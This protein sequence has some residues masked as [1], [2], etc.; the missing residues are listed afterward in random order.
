MVSC[1]SMPD[2]MISK[3]IDFTIFSPAAKFMAY[4]VFCVGGFSFSDSFFLIFSTFELSNTNKQI[5]NT[6]ITPRQMTNTYS[7]IIVTFIYKS[8]LYILNN[9]DL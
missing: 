5:S 6:C 4:I 1:T 7:S 9:I 3:N 8:I 2:K